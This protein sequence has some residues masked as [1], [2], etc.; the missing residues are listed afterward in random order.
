MFT[1]CREPSNLGD[2]QILIYC[3]EVPVMAVAG[4]GALVVFSFL[5][6]LVLGGGQ[7]AKK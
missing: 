1:E 7:S 2:G 3:S 4:A 5:L 6:G